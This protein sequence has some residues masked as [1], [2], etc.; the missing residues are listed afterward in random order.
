MSPGV[1]VEVLVPDFAGDHSALEEVV[2]AM[3]DVI[4]HNIETVPRL[5]ADVR[6]GA[7]YERSLSLI[8]QL[9]DGGVVSKSGLMLGLGETFQ[10]V[11]EVLGDLH[12]AGC[13]V[14]TLGQYL[15]PSKDCLAVADYIPPS[16][17]HALKRK[18]LAMGFRACVA[19]PL[20][21]SSY[22]AEATMVLGPGA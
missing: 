16:V 2:L 18:A 21:R 17:F 15:R 10:E 3:P 8:A 7:E 5:Y 11:F 9:A 19:G 14:L 12:S 13:E 20:V 4:G 22:H 6:R 1:T